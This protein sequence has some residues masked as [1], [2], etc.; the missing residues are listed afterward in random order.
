[1]ILL[2]LAEFLFAL[3]L[4]VY[5]EQL[6]RWLFPEPPSDAPSEGPDTA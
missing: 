1:M 6:A 3:G 2:G 5:G 4:M